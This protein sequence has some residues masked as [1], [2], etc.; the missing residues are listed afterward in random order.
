MVQ[1]MKRGLGSFKLPV[2]NPY[3]AGIKRQFSNAA[4][5]R[6]A[7]HGC[8]DAA[9]LE[10]AADQVGFGQMPG[11][12]EALE[13]EARLGEVAVTSNRAELSMQRDRSLESLLVTSGASLTLQGV[14]QWRFCAC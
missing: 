1:C 9:R 11:R 13:H 10:M 8:C 12:V 14:Q 2:L 5:Q 7:A 6:F 4:R 3:R